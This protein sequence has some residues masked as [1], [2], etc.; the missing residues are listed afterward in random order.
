M[1]CIKCGKEMSDDALFCPACGQ[2]VGEGISKPIIDEALLQE[3]VKK[4]QEGWQYAQDNAKKMQENIKKEGKYHQ[5]LIWG[6]AALVIVLCIVGV[7]KW[8]IK[9]IETDIVGEWRVQEGVFGAPVSS[10]E[11]HEDG[12]VRY[13]AVYG[14]YTLDKDELFLNITSGFTG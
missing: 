4:V 1:F 8:N 7:Y 5:I 11:F 10:M 6:V 14:Y 2:K 13:S 3:G 12:V 9:R